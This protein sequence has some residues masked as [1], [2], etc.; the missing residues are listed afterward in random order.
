MFGPATPTRPGKGPSM[1]EIPCFL[2]VLLTGAPRS[3]RMPSRE[4][5]MTG[6]KEK[7]PALSLD[8][9][10]VVIGLVLTALV[11]VGLPAIPW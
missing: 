2:P 3:K 7:R 1:A 4:E 9:W 10:T 11:L 8:W 6:D 5:Q